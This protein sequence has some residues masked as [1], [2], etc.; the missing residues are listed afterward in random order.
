MKRTIPILLLLVVFVSG[1]TLPFNPFGGD[2]VDVTTSVINEGPSDLVVIKDSIAI[3]HPPLLPNQNFI[4]SFVV[5]NRDNMKS[6]D[7]VVIDLYNAP[8]I[9]DSHTK[10]I[11][12][13]YDPNKKPCTPRQGECI[14]Q[15][16]LNPCTDSNKC[17][18]LPGEEKSINFDLLTPS[19]KEIVNIMTDISLNY[20]VKYSSG[21]SLLYVVPIINKD[22]IIKRQRAG[23]KTTLTV[24]KSLGS[25]P[26]KVDVELYGAPYILG[27][28]SAT[29]LFKLRNAGSGTLEE[30]NAIKIGNMK[31]IFP[32]DIFEVSNSEITSALSTPGEEP[33]KVTSLGQN[34]ADQTQTTDK[35]W[36]TCI[37]ENNNEIESVVCTNNREIPLYKDESRGSLRFE[38]SPARNIDEPF[39]SFSI[40]ATVVY[41]YELR[42]S[43]KISVNPFQNV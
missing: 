43:Y 28:E 40:Y 5:E 25:G 10:E 42:D 9:K 14:E 17:S 21:G 27:G 38:I 29:F 33:Q 15:C 13:V 12:N 41:N 2:V 34:I 18:I 35:P 24:S 30:N 37:K 4:F 23:E 22:E 26:V 36:F 31:I 32:M 7:N 1:C 19:E 3:P 8:L 20:K 11:C 16:E 39:R 6:A